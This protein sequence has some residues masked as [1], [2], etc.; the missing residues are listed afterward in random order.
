MF[1]NNHINNNNNNDDGNLKRLAQEPHCASFGLS[2]GS[3]NDDSSLLLIL[4]CLLI[5]NHF[6]IPL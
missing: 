3:N 1:T 6:L 4:I 5:L 2:L